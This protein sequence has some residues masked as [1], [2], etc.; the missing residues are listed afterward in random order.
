MTQLSGTPAWD[1]LAH[2]Y[3]AIR[4]VHMRDMFA[5]DPERFSRFSLS[6]EDM[7]LDYSKNRITEETM[8][9]LFALARQQ[10]VTGL[11]DAM[12]A[13]RRINLTEDR[14]VL[15]V[16]LRNRGEREY[17]VDGRNV[18]TQ[19]REV[20]QKMG[21][22]SES[23]RSGE[24]KGHTGRRILDV[25]NIGIGGSDLGPEMVTRALGKYHQ[26]GLKVHFVS[27]V[28]ATHMKRT[29][30]GLDPATTLFI[31]ASKTFTTQETLTNA[32]TA[33]DWVTDKLGEEAV[34]R[35]FVAVSTNR[36]KV[37]E[38]GID[39]EN[40]FEFWDWV[41]G[42]Y[43]LWSAIGLPIAVA[44]GMK[45]FEALLEGAHVMDEHFRTAPPEENMPVILGLLGL[46]YTDVFGAESY[47]VLPYEQ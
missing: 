41:G 42:R 26:V 43:S 29:V 2:H 9:H 16:A 10:N 30:R 36:E 8:K 21:T 46:W 19:V 28:D 24:W 12:F 33:R 7:L 18:M 45:N 4:D 34:A 22:F 14:A 5:G 20:L 17:K 40:M 37:A 25:V 35:H 6:V 1:S 27:N 11:R 47:A 32:H 38:F 15:H 3:K 23:V 31:V 44:V 39:P 13:G